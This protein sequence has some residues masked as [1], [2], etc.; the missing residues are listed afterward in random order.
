AYT[1][2]VLLVYALIVTLLS[3]TQLGKNAIKEK[4][5]AK[6]NALLLFLGLIP[7]IISILLFIYIRPSIFGLFSGGYTAIGFFFGTL[8]WSIAIL[9][10][11]AFQLKSIDPL[12]REY[13]LLTKLTMPVFNLFYSMVDKKSWMSEVFS[14][15]IYLMKLIIIKENELKSDYGYS[16]IKRSSILARIFGEHLK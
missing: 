9:N 14:R 13:R 2:K 5:R 8:I 12:P 3:L 7:P 6:T 4:G 11:D 10:C 16:V 1:Y 15:K